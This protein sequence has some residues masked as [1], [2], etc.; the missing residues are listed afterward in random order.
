MVIELNDL[1]HVYDD[2]LSPD[3]CNY[4]IKF[5]EDNVDK[6]EKI[7]IEKKPSFSQLNFTENHPQTED[8]IKIHMY[9]ISRVLD[10]KKKY[11]EYVDS[12]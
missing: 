5:Y 4:L 9:V 6:V 3:I 10:Y 11:Y 1:I 8:S 7:D 12:R 2:V